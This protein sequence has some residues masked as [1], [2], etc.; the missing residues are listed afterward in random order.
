MGNCFSTNMNN[1]LVNLKD[2]DV[3]FFS[4]DGMEFDAKVVD[5]YDGDTCTVI[6]N[7]KDEPVK[8]KCRC[9]GYDSPEMKPSKNIEDSKRAE[10]IKNAHIA[11][12]FFI[13]EVTN[14]N[15]NINENFD[16]SYIKSILSNNSRIVQIKTYEWDKYGR[17][18]ADFYYKGKNINN[19]M[20]TNGHGYSYDGGTKRV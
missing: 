11:K 1:E 12:Y 4:F 13:N 10:I 18:L 5:V 2:G 15:I 7:F 19:L 16:K 9:K 6:F 8:F 17:L 14:S 3:E 20:I